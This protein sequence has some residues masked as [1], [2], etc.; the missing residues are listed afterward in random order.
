[1]VHERTVYYILYWTVSRK[2]AAHPDERDRI[3]GNRCL[4][5]A[6]GRELEREGAYDEMDYP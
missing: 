2:L 3:S 4:G 6:T 5:S 1:M